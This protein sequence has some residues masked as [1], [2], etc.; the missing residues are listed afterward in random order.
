MALFPTPIL[1]IP[2]LVNLAF[3]I[4][5]ARC[6][7][8]HPRPPLSIILFLLIFGIG[9]IRLLFLVEFS[10]FSIVLLTVLSAAFCVAMTLAMSSRRLWG[11]SHLKS[12]TIASLVVIPILTWVDSR[13]RI[14]VVDGL[15]RS[16]EV[17][18]TNINFQRPNTYWYDF[19]YGHGTA[20]K[21][22]VVYFGFCQWVMF[23]DDWIIFG[24]VRKPLGPSTE[25]M[26]AKPDWNKWPIKLTVRTP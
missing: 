23:R 10:V 16:F 12:W 8:K 25:F 9:S 15:G 1:W 4:W 2:C 20:V 21:K 11:C 5:V 22:G 6:F 26:I 18:A 7:H 17:D 13:F 24:T 14:D 3:S 19:R